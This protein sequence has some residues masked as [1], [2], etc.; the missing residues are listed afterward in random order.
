MAEA[1]VKGVA[2]GLHVSFTQSL[3]GSDPSYDYVVTRWTRACRL[4]T[5]ATR[6]RSVTDDTK[7][8]L[9]FIRT[10]STGLPERLSSRG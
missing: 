3:S 2:G 6:R 4:L 5:V 1:W 9:G 7:A 8:S 10:T